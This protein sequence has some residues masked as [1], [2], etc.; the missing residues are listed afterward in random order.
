M[1]DQPTP[2][3]P[4]YGNEKNLSAQTLHEH[5]GLAADGS[6]AKTGYGAEPE[7]IP[8]EGSFFDTTLPRIGGAVPLAAWFIVVNEF[9]ER[10]AYYGGSA[11]FQNYIAK[12]AD[13]QGGEFGGV[14]KGQATATAMSNLFTFLCYL[15]PLFGAI[16][17]DQWLGK[18]RTILTFSCIYLVGFVILTATAVPTGHL[19]DGAPIYGAAAFPGYVAAIIIIGL[20]TGGIKS[21]VSPMCADQVPTESY[22]VVKGGKTY[23]VDPDMTTQ[24]LYNWF[25]WAINVGAMIGQLICTH[26]EK[27]AFWKAYLLPACMFV[28]SICIFLA[29]HKK[30]RHVK[31]E[32]SIIVESF[33]C[34]VYAVKRKRAAPNAPVQ[35]P[36]GNQ[37][38]VSFKFLS[39]AEPYAG[40]PEG[41]VAKRPWAADFPAE[42]R[43]TLKAC[44]I[45]PLMSLYWVAYNQMTNNLVSQAGQM[46][47][48]GWIT[49]DVVSILD[50]IALV[51]MIPIF[52]MGIFPLL[53]RMN[54]DFGYIKRISFGFILGGLSMAY[55]AIVQHLI[56]SRGPYYDY[57]TATE[58]QQLDN[59]HISVYI[60]FPAYIIMALSEI[61]ASIGSLEYSY[62]HAPKRMKCLI[63]ALSLLPNAVASLIG[64]F[65][66]PVAVNPSLVWLYTG[67]AVA[68]A[69]SGVI[70]WFLFRKF[71]EQDKV[72]KRVAR[73][74]EEEQNGRGPA[75]VQRE[76]SEAEAQDRLNV[77]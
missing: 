53:H 11:V 58:D 20:G 41:E 47:L 1:T 64:I 21:V 33:K 65:L 74:A 4:T 61:F 76:E 44:S 68:A 54:V 18:F 12:D 45:F 60:Q 5:R 50:P 9:C 6:I 26:L 29:G 51:I 48:P 32:G 52:D 8:Y 31:P 7:R 17:A 15:T 56:Y 59:N 72:L 69:V 55:A 14:G 75:A 3:P 46:H 42:L 43:Q 40:E 28:L 39:W 71:D 30:Y 16:V 62:T 66:S 27:S 36:G 70:F 37:D 24:H 67:I 10:F 73:N 23:I 38:E 34:I 22:T 63:S 25:Y 49:N 2:P 77:R 57:S 19:D 35:A 13:N